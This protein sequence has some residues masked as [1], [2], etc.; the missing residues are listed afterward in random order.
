[1]EISPVWTDGIAVMMLKAK[2]FDARAG[3]GLRSLFARLVAAGVRHLV[4]DFH[5]VRAVDSAG[6]AAVLHFLTQCQRVPCACILC[7]PLGRVRTVFELIGLHRVVEVVNS[8]EEAVRA[9][10]V[11]GPSEKPGISPVVTACAD[12]G[13]REGSV[14]MLVT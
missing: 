4:L 2:C 9:F 14:P 6:C 7:A 8:V 12:Q 3:Q 5:E 10:R 11:S 1:M 13:A